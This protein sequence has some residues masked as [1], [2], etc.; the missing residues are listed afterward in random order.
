ME[1]KLISAQASRDTKEALWTTHNAAKYV[2]SLL[3][4]LQSSL[5]IDA[6]DKRVLGQ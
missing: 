2:Q 6:E 4:L 3:E 1:R 5:I